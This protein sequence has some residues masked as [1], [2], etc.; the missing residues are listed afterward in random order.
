MS[1][2]TLHGGPWNGCTITDSGAVTIRMGIAKEWD[3]NRPKI[4]TECGHAHYEPT[5][6]RKSAH[7]LENR[8]DGI[9]EAIIEA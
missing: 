5:E 8:W 7:W 6:D 2:I 9:V 4:G 1:K 3:W